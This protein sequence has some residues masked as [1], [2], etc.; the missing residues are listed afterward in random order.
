MSS[1]TFEKDL[2]RELKSINK[3]LKKLNQSMDPK[4]IK[5][6]GDMLVG[7]DT[8]PQSDKQKQSDRWT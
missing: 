7:T 4:P 3:E 5:L 1:S 2:I 6:N 8:A